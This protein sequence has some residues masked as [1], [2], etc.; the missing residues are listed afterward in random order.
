[1]RD[2]SKNP[3]CSGCQSNKSTNQTSE[4]L[5]TLFAPSKHEPTGTDSDPHKLR[6]MGKKQERREMS[7]TDKTKKKK[8]DGI[9]S[10]ELSPRSFMQ[11]EIHWPE[12]YTL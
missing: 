1:M 4:S 7:S 3:D 10:E 5:Y 2:L 12:P 6:K 9:S 8:M 11:Y